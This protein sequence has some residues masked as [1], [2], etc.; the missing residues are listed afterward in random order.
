MKQIK[1]KRSMLLLSI[2]GILAVI[3]M[4]PSV[5]GFTGTVVPNNIVNTYAIQSGTLEDIKYEDN[6]YVQWIGLTTSW[7]IFQ[8]LTRVY[9]PLKT[10]VGSGNELEMEFY[11]SGGAVCD[12]KIVYTDLSY[13]T[14]YESS[15]NW[16][17]VIYDLDDNKIVYYVQ[18][19]NYEWWQGGILQVDYMEVNY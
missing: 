9:Y 4:S 16:K 19:W 18:F 12:V 13:D 1:K 7:F 14:Y 10:D 8:I 17:T 2:I 11:F 6:D 5:L 15:T 3:A